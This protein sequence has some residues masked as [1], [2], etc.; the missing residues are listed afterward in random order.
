MKRRIIYFS[1]FTLLVSGLFAAKIE[2][3]TAD[4][5]VQLVKAKIT[6]TKTF[7]GS[8]VYSYNGKNNWG[9][10]EYK[11]PNKFLMS[12]S[13]NNSSGQSYDTGQKFISD[14]KV[15]CLYFKSQNIAINETLEKSTIPLVGWN[16]NRLLK[17]FVP[18][19]PK[20]NSYKVQYQ[21]QEAFKIVFVPRS[22]TAGFKT[23][24][25][26]VSHDGDILKLDAVNQLGVT[27]EL[28]IT[29]NSFNN[30]ISDDA[31]DYEHLFDEQTQVFQ[32]ILLPRGNDAVDNSG[33]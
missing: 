23:I 4:N 31:F 19:L 14:G 3:F 8:F 21:K 26:I 24:N 15:L 22:T 9:S 6:K 18:S 16:I 33:Q 1:I 7:T 32:N 12:F 5:I 28:G 25:M 11:S 29:Y 20:N 17:E 27:V 30:A 2:V 13:D 10:I